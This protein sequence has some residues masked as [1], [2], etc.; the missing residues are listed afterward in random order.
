MK[1]RLQLEFPQENHLKKFFFSLSFRNISLWIFI[2]TFCFFYFY[3]RR[4]KILSHLL[5]E[6][7][8]SLLHLLRF[9]LGA[10]CWGWREKKSVKC[11]FIIQVLNLI[12]FD[13]SVLMAIF[14]RKRGSWG[15]RGDIWTMIILYF[16]IHSRD[17]FAP[18]FKPIFSP[19]TV[20]LNK[21][22][23]T[24]WWDLFFWIIKSAGRGKV[25]T[26]V[27]HFICTM[28]ANF[29]LMCAR[30]RLDLP[31]REKLPKTSRIFLH[32]NANSRTINQTCLHIPKRQN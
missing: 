1:F 14:C 13:G 16:G 8:I 4:M 2:N 28:T 32:I 17:S 6:N 18:H 30:W 29:I 20:I 19:S 31:A 11:E 3:D 15:G 25:R 5:K 24:F 23:I 7:V 12:Y 9:L 21:N 10:G 27:K 26:S 22:W